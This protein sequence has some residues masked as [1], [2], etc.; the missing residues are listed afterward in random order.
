MK[1]VFLFIDGVGVRK[2]AADNPVNK[3]VC[4]VLCDLI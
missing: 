3:E 1:I 2:D 4:P